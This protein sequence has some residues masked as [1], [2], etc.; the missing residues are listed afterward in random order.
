MGR[1]QVFMAGLKRSL[2][3]VAALGLTV[4]GCAAGPSIFTTAPEALPES[5]G[6]LPN[7]APAVPKTPYPFPAVHDTPPARAAKPLD[8]D[9]LQKTEQDLEST[10]YSQIKR[11]TDTPDD[12]D[13][14]NAPAKPAPAKPAATKKKPS[15]AKKKPGAAAQAGAPTSP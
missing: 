14:D 4:A 9:Q 2:I 10:R 1:L 8:T 13:A 5:M 6:G 15:A 12:F 7:D 3:A 11:A